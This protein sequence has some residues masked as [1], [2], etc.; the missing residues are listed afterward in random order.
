M[1]SEICDTDDDDD[2]DD[3]DEGNDGR[4]CE[5]VWDGIILQK[6]CDTIS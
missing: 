2:D 1:W 5:I 3:D 4:L 6:P